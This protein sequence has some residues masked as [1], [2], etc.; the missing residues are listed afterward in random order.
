[1]RIF[2]LKYNNYRSTFVDL[3]RVISISVDA[4]I[5]Y[6]TMTAPIA[7]I[8]GTAG[9]IRTI[10]ENQVEAF[11]KAWKN[12]VPNNGPYRGPSNINGPV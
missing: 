11:I 7:H 6:F 12:E 5:A 3:D 9:H 2:E 4:K 8:N 10:P 1:M